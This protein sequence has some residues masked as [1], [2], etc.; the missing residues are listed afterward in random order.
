[1]KKRIVPF[2]LLL[3]YVF[4]LIKVLVLK[5]LAMVKLGQ[6]RFNFGGTQEG[7]ANL[8]PFKT[9]LF[10]LQGH[11]GFLIGAINVLGNI[12]A[13][14][15]LGFLVPFVFEKTNWKKICLLAFASGLSI[16]TIQV[17][18]HIGIFDIDDVILNALGVII[19]FWK[20]HLFMKFPKQIQNK[21]S[22]LVFTILFLLMFLFTLSYYKFIELPIGIEPSIE[23][24]KLPLLPNQTSNPNECCDLCNGTGGTGVIVAKNENGIMIK[25]RKGK[26]EFIKIAPRT[27]IKNSK[28][29]ILKNTLAIGDHVTVVIDESETAA[30]VLVCGIAK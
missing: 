24:T 11:N 15:P 8:I 2:L 28:G 16:E 13:L 18:L 25:S 19:G 12:I 21:L 20:Y 4:I 30:L 26:E 14:V 17:I 9:I 3:L 27:E 22:I 29:I 10:Y 1:M 7:P 23:R 6:L 5:D